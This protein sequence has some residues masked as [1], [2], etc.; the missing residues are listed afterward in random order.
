MSFLPEPK[1]T[2]EE[3]KLVTNIKEQLPALE[4]LLTEASGQ[5]GYEDP[6]YRF[7]HQSFKVY[8]VQKVTRRVLENLQS[9][10][11]HLS[12]NKWF[13][14]IVSSGTVKEFTPKDNDDWTNITRPVVEAFFHA[15]YMLEMVCK[16]GAQLSGA[17]TRIP[18]GWGSVLYLFNL[19]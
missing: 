1:R 9:L 2:E 19:R 5:W 14:Q 18:T 3:Q 15:H 4:K 7:Y 17:V 8:D 10:A 12:M 6:I 13:M 11:P 16:Y